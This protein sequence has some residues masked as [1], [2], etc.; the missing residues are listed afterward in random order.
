MWLMSNL[1]LFLGLM[2]AI[3]AIAAG[4]AFWGTR[5]IRK[6]AQQDYTYKHSRGMIDHRLSEDGY[7]RAYMRF[8]GPRKYIFMAMAFASVA[9]F[10]VPMLGLIRATL[11]KIWEMG[12]RSDDIQPDLLVFNLLMMV[13]LLSFWALIFFICARFYYNRAPVSLRDEMLK[14][15]D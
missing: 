10:T 14:E 8:Y 13:S 9:L 11:I 5:T 3:A 2:A 7:K 15:M 4:R 12:G 1:S 6:D